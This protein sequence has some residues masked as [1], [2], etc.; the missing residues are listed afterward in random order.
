MITCPFCQ[1]PV[2][3][4]HHEPQQVDSLKYLS[5]GDHSNFYC[6]TKVDIIKMTEWPHYQ[7]GG[8]VGH[9]IHGHWYQALVP[10]FRITWW[11][12]NNFIKVQQFGGQSFT[13]TYEKFDT[14]WE[15]FLKIC[16]RFQ[17]LR[18]FA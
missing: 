17:N 4:L 6:S 18:A 8:Y 3:S 13:S 12:K 10:P 15:G 11:D 16:Q 14:D 7:R 1:Q 9:E 2:I 5:D